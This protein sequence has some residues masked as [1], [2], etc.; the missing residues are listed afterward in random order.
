[1]ESLLR[2]KFKVALKNFGSLHLTDLTFLLHEKWK[3]S[4]LIHC[5][6]CPKV[7]KS[8]TCSLFCFVF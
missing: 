4:V 1:M 5:P 6:I 3:D 8:I 7:N 2:F